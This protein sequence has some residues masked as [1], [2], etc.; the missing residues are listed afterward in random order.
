MSDFAPSAVRQVSP[1]VSLQNPMNTDS[2]DFGF[3]C[4]FLARAWGGSRRRMVDLI[5]HAGRVCESWVQAD[6]FLEAHTYRE[7]SMPHFRCNSQPEGYGGPVDWSYWDDNRHEAA[8][9]GEIAADGDGGAVPLMLAAAILVRGV[10]VACVSLVPD[11]VRNLSP[12][13][14]ILAIAVA[15]ISGG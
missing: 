14:A 8:D 15:C 13:L 12:V 5:L 7:P 6:L 3:W 9:E 1:V 4:A 2:R 10:A 11:I